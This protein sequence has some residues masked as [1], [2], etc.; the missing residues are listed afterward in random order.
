MKTSKK[1]SKSSCFSGQKAAFFTL[2]FF[3][4]GA[5]A[6]GFCPCSHASE[7]PSVSV[8]AASGHGH[9]CCAKTAKKET[10]KD[11]SSGGCL[12][13]R[14]AELETKADFTAP[15]A[16]GFQPELLPSETP[17]FLEG[18]REVSSSSEKAS[19]APPQPLYVLFRSLLI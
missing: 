8:K 9:D 2:L 12:H 14:T 4:F 15:S 17:L 10:S 6:A 11:C 7:M 16:D 3:V 18:L 1:V 19:G 5:V 13:H